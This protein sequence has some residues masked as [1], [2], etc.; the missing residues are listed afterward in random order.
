ML[1][2]SVSKRTNS[3]LFGQFP[4]PAICLLLVTTVLSCGRAYAAFP[5]GFSAETVVRNLNK[6]VAF[7][8]APGNRIYV[9]EKYGIVRTVI[10]GRVEREPFM[11]ISDRV[12]TYN[13]R[14]LVA[15]AVDPSFPTKPYIYVGYAYDPPETATAGG[16]AGRDGEGSRVSRVSRFTASASTQ[17]KTVEANSEVV[18]VGK[19]GVWSNIINPNQNWQ[20][21]LTCQ[22]N[23]QPVKD[24]L[25][26]DE[27][28]HTVG[29]L[30]FGSDG[31]LYV[32]AGD[33]SRSGDVSKYPAIRAQRKDFLIGKILRV[34]PANGQG[35]SS[36]P[37]FDGDLTSNVSKVWFYGLRNPFR[38]AIRNRD[39]RVF[40]GNVGWENWEEI[41][42]GSPGANFGWPCYEG[43]SGQLEVHAQHANNEVCQALYASNGS[44]VTPPLYGY[45]K[46]NG[47]SVSIIMGDFMENQRWPSRYRGG[48]FFGDFNRQVIDYVTFDSS[49]NVSARSG[50]GTGLGGV[51]QLSAGPDQDLY[52]TVV[53]AGEIRAIRYQAGD[54]PPTAS[55]TM[56][57]TTGPAPLLVQ[58]DASAS[59]DPDGDPITYR[60][61]FG[62]GGTGTGKNINHTFSAEGEYNIRLTVSDDAGGSDTTTQK[63][64]VGNKAPNLGFGAESEAEVTTRRY[65]VGE[66]VAIT[67]WGNDPEDGALTGGR[68]QW[69]AVIHHNNHSHPDLGAN[70]G[71][72][73]FIPFPDHGENTYVEICLKAT[74]TTGLSSTK[75][76]DARPRDV[77]I[78][79]NSDPPGQRIDYAGVEKRTPFK[80][81]SVA[82]GKRDITAPLTTSDGRQFVRWSDGGSAAHTL[83]IPDTPLA[84]KVFYTANA[85][86]IDSDNDGLTDAEEALWGTDPNVADPDNDN[87]GVINLVD[88][89]PNDRTESGQA[90]LL[91][92]GP[93]DM[94]PRGFGYLGM[95]DYRSVLR[96]AF[97]NPDRDVRLK[98]VG[99]DIDTPGEVS[100]WLIGKNGRPQWIG[101]LAAGAN[102]K[103]APASWFYIPESMLGEGRN[104]VEFRQKRRGEIWGIGELGMRALTAP[105]TR[106]LQL[107]RVYEARYGFRYGPTSY[108]YVL[109]FLFTNNNTD[110]SFEFDAF[111]IDTNREVAVVLN[112][113]RIAYVRRTGN[114]RTGRR[115]VVDSTARSLGC[116][117]SVTE[118][119]AV[120]VGVLELNS[121]DCVNAVHQDRVR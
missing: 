61:N 32:S 66:I 1:Q 53:D 10:D 36:N 76:I 31:A 20:G 19:N 13:D 25:P 9:A 103:A 92:P 60:W 110:L 83:T 101:D 6:P 109:P 93:S 69:T 67:G 107:N 48:L 88:S 73:F 56:S 3:S 50:F 98:A 64:S 70:T 72:T 58:F 119:C 74:D 27:H 14:G 89:R 68:L 59:V 96:A 12:N 99:W 91:A 97:E 115:Q 80:V 35:Y 84:L 71:S 51:T 38:F 78:S 8:F 47:I 114:L 75:C 86:E 33:A 105:R 4:I 39:N 15:I 116:E 2:Q 100:L 42:T 113:K 5:G 37:F 54:P 102:R 26:L 7:D 111:D 117:K 52:Y 30:Q 85:N 82:G 87:D 28:S 46:Q 90:V 40:V 41:E 104:W 57:R 95:N 45:Q 112:G 81:E 43:G 94:T 118:T 63:V 21:A 34:N 62:D 29:M 106:R 55:F 24:C 120:T 79:V 22:F 23:D 77:E 108:R 49:G 11:D 44:S 16:L 121:G 18:L 17:Y 65:R